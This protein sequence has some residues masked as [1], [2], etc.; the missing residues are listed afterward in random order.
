MHSA[1]KYFGGHSD[2]MGGALIAPP[3]KATGG[4]V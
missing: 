4:K 1:T 2:L 3:K